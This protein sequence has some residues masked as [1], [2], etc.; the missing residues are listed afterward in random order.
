ML[1]RAAGR[2]EASAPT[3]ACARIASRDR[4]FYGAQGGVTCVQSTFA[5]ELL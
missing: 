1:A 3:G 4:S 2:T 5:L